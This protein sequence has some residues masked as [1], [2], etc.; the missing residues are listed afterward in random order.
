MVTKYRRQIAA[1]V[2][3]ET[4]QKLCKHAKATGN[5][6]SVYL[7]EVVTNLVKALDPE[8]P[9]KSTSTPIDSGQAKIGIPKEPPQVVAA[10]P[11]KQVK[12]K[13]VVVETEP[14]ESLV[15]EE[16]VSYGWSLMNVW[17]RFR[18]FMTREDD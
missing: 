15:E 1:R 9:K 6:L 14:S 18:D 11:I 5:S 13:P 17:R 8:N 12:R 10:K 3:E 4:Y 7:R 2:D 16:T